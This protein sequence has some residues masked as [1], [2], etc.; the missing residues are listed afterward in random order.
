MRRNST[1]RHWGALGTPLNGWILSAMR[2]KKVTIRNIV[3][4]ALC[5]AGNDADVLSRVYQKYESAAP[6]NVF[7]YL[8]LWYV[9]MYLLSLRVK[10]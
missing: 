4:T 9:P 7:L 2:L 8:P 3:P 6:N 1:P 5:G 10:R